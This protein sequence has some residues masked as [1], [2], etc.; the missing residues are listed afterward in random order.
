[1]QNSERMHFKDAKNKWNETEHRVLHIFSRWRI[2]SSVQH[3]LHFFH[4]IISTYF[5]SCWGI[6]NASGNRRKFPRQ[7][8]YS[9]AALRTRRTYWYR[10][11]IREAQYI[12]LEIAWLGLRN[13]PIVRCFHLRF[14]NY[15]MSQQ[16]VLFQVNHHSQAYLWRTSWSDHS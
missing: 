1:M 12:E 15:N 7:S 14:V 10:L 2:F 5:K 13:F 6:C 8:M 9:Y 3:S 11:A 16:M 4:G